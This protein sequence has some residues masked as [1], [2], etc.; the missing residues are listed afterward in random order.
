MAARA[1]HPVGRSALPACGEAPPGAWR[2]A[3]SRRAATT[4]SS[5]WRRALAALSV[6]ALPLGACLDI[7]D[8]WYVTRGLDGVP[9]GP[10]DFDG[11]VRPILDAYGCLTCHSS[12]AGSGRL[13]VRSA[14]SLLAGGLSGPATVPCEPEQS[15]LFQ[16]VADCSMPPTDNCLSG[17]ALATL[18]RWIAQGAQADFD[19]DLCPDPPLD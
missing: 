16:R 7:G 12:T 2:P 9:S 18:E 5:L 14:E 13:D 17:D 1:P 8:P 3:P 11:H 4:R 15:V 10:L 6:L 19:P